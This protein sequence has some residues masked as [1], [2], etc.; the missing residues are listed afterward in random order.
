MR[1]GD[2]AQV[3]DALRYVPS[4][5]RDTWI[6]MGMAVKEA[7]GEQGFDLWDRWSAQSENYQARVARQQWRSFKYGRGISAGTLFHEAKLNGWQSEKSLEQLL[8][9]TRQS[10]EQRRKEQEEARRQA[11]A[12]ALEAAIQAGVLRHLAS[13]IDWHPYLA[14]KQIVPRFRDPWKRGHFPW[15]AHEGKLLVIARNFFKGHIQSAQLIDDMGEKK[16]LPGSRM[17][18][19]VYRIHGQQRYRRIWF[20]EG[21]ATGW[22]IHKALRDQCW[23]DPVVVCFSAGNLM[24]AR[25]CRRSFIVADNDE[26]ETGQQYA[27]RAVGERYWMPPEIGMDANDFYCQ[28]GSL[29]LGNELFRT[30]NRCARSQHLPV[31]AHS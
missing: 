26:S 19:A 15:L 8:A 6:R 25:H 30:V 17:K 5:D 23:E 28:E 2:Y 31:G 1:G 16:F 21:F 22:T 18:D 24:L 12:D 29:S 11:D 14:T 10:Q 27:E 4:H 20:C 7:L 3:Q 13:T 9:T